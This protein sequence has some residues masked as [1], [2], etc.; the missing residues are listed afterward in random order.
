[1]PD[2][3]ERQAYLVREKLPP[4]ARHAVNQEPCTQYAVAFQK[5]CFARAERKAEC[6]AG[7]GLIRLINNYL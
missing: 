6:Y 7:Q 3:R 4:A 2:G 1:M 5:C